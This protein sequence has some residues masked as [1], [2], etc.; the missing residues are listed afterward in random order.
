MICLGI[1]KN[2]TKIFHLTCQQ[3]V[4]TNKT[5][6]ISIIYIMIITEHFHIA[7]NYRTKFLP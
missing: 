1:P 4:R 5:S 3:A 6:K 7:G 2:I